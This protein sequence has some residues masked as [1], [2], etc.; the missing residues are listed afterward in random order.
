MKKVKIA[1]LGLG[2]VG[3]GTYDILTKNRD[4]ILERTGVDY[5]ISHIFDVTSGL[6]GYAGG[7]GAF[8]T[9]MWLMG[10]FDSNT[11]PR[12]VKAM[13]GENVEAIRKVL[14]DNGLL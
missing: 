14:E 5:E 11:M 3:G 6:Q 12:P 1:L 8:K 10:I 2:T 9:A 7:V 4:I 13:E